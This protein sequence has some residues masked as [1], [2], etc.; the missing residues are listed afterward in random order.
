LIWRA[1]W[2]CWPMLG[3]CLPFVWLGIRCCWRCSRGWSAHWC[4]SS[5]RQIQLARQSLLRV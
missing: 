1:C 5:S 2:T 3:Y 4:P